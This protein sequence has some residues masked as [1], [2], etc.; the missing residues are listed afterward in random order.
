[1]EITQDTSQKQSKAIL[2]RLTPEI[3]DKCK[4]ISEK[5]NRPLSQILRKMIEGALKEG[6]EVV[7]PLIAPD[8]APPE[9][10]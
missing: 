3:Y 2:L 8:G 1:M 5:A 7:P 9:T 10:S 6:V 4:A